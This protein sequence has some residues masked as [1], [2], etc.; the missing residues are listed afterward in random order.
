MKPPSPAT[1][2]SALLK[3]AS[4]TSLVALPPAAFSANDLG[5]L[6]RTAV[7]RSA[8]I[9]DQADSVWQQVAGEVVPAWQK[10]Q[11]LAA[12]NEPPPFLDETFASELL[13]LP[14]VV[15]AQ[16]AGVP[17]SVLTTMLPAARN[18][19]VL[20]YA[21][22]GTGPAPL[23][24][25]P[26]Y[27]KATGGAARGTAVRGFPRELAAAAED[28]TVPL[29]NSTLFNF[30]SYV[31]WRVLQSVL[32]DPQRS[33]LERKR[34][35]RAFDEKLGCALLEGPLRDAALPTAA[36]GVGGG[37]GG[38]GDRAT[39]SLK[40]AVEG[41]GALLSLMRQRGLF[42][43][44]SLQ[45]SLGSGS[46]LFDEG[47]WQAGGSTSWQY[48]IAGSAIVGGSQLAQ[49]RT[50]ATGMGAGLYPGQLLTAPLSVYLN[51]QLGIRS[52]IDE[53]F[54][55]NRVGR[56]DPRTFSDPRYYSEVLLEIVALEE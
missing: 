2:R 27:G 38:G 50:A 41:C 37:G 51:R 54:L 1:R 39:R 20:L 44:S 5:T 45:L 47:D 7:V 24:N 25:E 15:G 4:V 55:D 3:F 28:G 23:N 33:P 40:V 14:L 49:D 34:L 32:S 26:F 30:E 8:Q 29:A 43:T 35:Q 22:G 46:D 48:V 19:A 12:Q 52:R 42:S 9:A 13:T 17:L 6:V 10:P 31:R 18:E 21:D 11:A 36:D 16:V 53:Y 56:P